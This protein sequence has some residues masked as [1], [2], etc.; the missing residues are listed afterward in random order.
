MMQPGDTSAVDVHRKTPMDRR[1]AVT[2]ATVLGIVPV[3]VFIIQPGYVQGLVDLARLTGAEAGYIASAE[4]TGYALTV[5]AL[6]FLSHR[7][8][9][10]PM[11]IGFVLVQA[12]GA[13]AQPT[14]RRLC[15]SRMTAR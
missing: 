4:M 12:L 13:A 3:L 6:S 14:T 11:L 2:A 1:F 7:L 9:W 8:P 10:H 15:R 5:I